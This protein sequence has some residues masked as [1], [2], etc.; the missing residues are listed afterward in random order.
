M[1]AFKPGQRYTRDQIHDAVGGSKEK[2]LPHV[3]GAVVAGCFDPIKNPMAPQ[4]VLP[5]STPDRQRWASVFAGQRAGVPCFVKRDTN[6]WEYV[7]RYRCAHQS[8]D[9]AEIA[10]HA[11]RTGRPEISQVLHLE[12]AG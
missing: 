11:K 8:F 6:A 4:V 3:G 5:G 2:F 10:E 1:M 9:R 7:G 12:A